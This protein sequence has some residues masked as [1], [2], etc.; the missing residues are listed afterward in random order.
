M[1]LTLHQLRVFVKVAETLN[2]SQAAR[3]LLLSQPAVSMQ[4]KALERGLGMPLFDRVGKRISLSVAGQ[5]LYSRALRILGLVDETAQTM[6]DLRTGRK[7]RLRVVAT[8]TVGIYV[9]PQLLGQFHNR[10]PEVEIHLEVANWERTCE[11]LF[12]GEADIAVA[13]PQLHPQ[14]QMEPFMDDELVVIAS[15]NHHLARREKVSLEELSAEPM[16]LRER[17]SGTRAAV[18][19]LF[20]DHALALRGAMELSRNGAIKQVAKAGLGVAVLSRT[21][22]DLE[23][24]ANELTILDVEAFPIV[25]SWLIITRSGLNLPPAAAAFCSQ[26]R[27]RASG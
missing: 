11:R 14:L 25:R 6:S 2:F 9:V 8:T 3:E 27:S 26:V 21:C 19:R 22:L 17:G 13:G 23:I 20:H 1:E 18:D 4:M 10:H 12:S 7:G 16:L 15:P 24:A 5:D